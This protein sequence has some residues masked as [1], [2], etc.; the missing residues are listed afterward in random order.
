VKQKYTAWTV[1]LVI[2]GSLVAIQAYSQKREMRTR[3][4]QFARALLLLTWQ[5][6]LTDEQRGQI[7]S[8][9]RTELPT[10]EPFLEQLAAG[11]QQ[12]AAATRNGSFN[13]GEVQAIANQ[14]SQAIAQLIV[15]KERL[16]SHVYNEVLTPEQ[17]SKADAMRQN[18]AQR[19][20][21]RLQGRP[22][23]VGPGHELSPTGAP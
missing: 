20:N 5:L 7:N 16:L 2:A 18:W 14:Q 17:R 1:I 22:A 21:D 19:M 15:T 8:M 13:E 23:P 6:G 11:E 10:A 9:V 3:G 12:M 4:G